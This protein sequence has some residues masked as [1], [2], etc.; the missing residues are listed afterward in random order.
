[1]NTLQTYENFSSDVLDTNKWF[2]LEIPV[3]EG[4]SRR[5]EEPHAKVTIKDGVLEVDIARFETFHDQVQMFDSG[6]QAYFSTKSFPLPAQR[7]AVFSVEM[8]VTNHGGN[9]D[10]VRDAFASFNV[11]DLASGAV[12]DAIATSR[13]L[14]AL[15]ERLQV[16]GVRAEDVFTYIV[17]APLASLSTEPGQF[18][19]YTITFDRANRRACW[20]VDGTRV[21]ALDNLKVFPDE[22]QIGFGIFTLHPLRQGKSTALRGQGMRSRWR[23]FRYAI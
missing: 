10:D 19:E 9:P 1:M 14:Y 15:H 13:R 21:Y 23:N 11:V 5:Y 7:E 16:P 22:V 2:I 4:E 18:H 6:K 12:F 17:E 3:G 8:A 20:Y